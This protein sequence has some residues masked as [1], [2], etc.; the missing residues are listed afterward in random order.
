MTIIILLIS[1]VFYV[2]VDFD[3]AMCRETKETMELGLVF[4]IATR[5]K[6]KGY[7]LPTEVGVAKFPFSTEF[8][9]G[10]WFCSSLLS[11]SVL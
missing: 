9:L 3:V 1:I 8:S 2:L 6:V 10:V 5:T 7:A 11:D 4:R